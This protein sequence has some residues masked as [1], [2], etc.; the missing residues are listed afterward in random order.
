MTGLGS[1]VKTGG[2]RGDRSFAVLPPSLKLGSDGEVQ[3]RP[4]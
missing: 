2:G 3:T 1:R 4:H